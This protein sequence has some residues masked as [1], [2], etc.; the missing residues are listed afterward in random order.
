MQSII[1]LCILAATFVAVFFI[2]PAELGVLVL[3]L[4]IGISSAWVD[5]AD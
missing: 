2:V 4:G 1:G 3:L 5:T